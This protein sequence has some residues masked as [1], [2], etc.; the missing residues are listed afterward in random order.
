MEEARRESSL[1]T[2]YK[3]LAYTTACW[4]DGIKAGETGEEGQLGWWARGGQS[5]GS[6]GEE[7][8]REIQ[9]CPG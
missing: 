9:V 4:G 3:K 7:D 6:G 2:H 1:Y 5:G 8:R